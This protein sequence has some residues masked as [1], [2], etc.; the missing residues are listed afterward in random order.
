LAAF[1]AAGIRVGVGTDSAASI[2]PPDL[3]AEARAARRIAQLSAIEVLRLITLEAALA[4][5]LTDIGLIAPG[6]WADLVILRIAPGTVRI[7]DEAEIM[8]AVLAAGP[9]DVQ[10]TWVAGREVFRT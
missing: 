8:E 9:A 7:L 6:A 4:I 2:G 10:A 1:L 3:L 5:G